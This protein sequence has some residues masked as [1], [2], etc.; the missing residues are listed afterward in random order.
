M[1]LGGTTSLGNLVICRGFALQLARKSAKMQAGYCWVVHGVLKIEI[2]MVRAPAQD[3]ILDHP[4]SCLD[5]G[6][7]HLL[8]LVVDVWGVRVRQ[9]VLP[10]LGLRLAPTALSELSLIDSDR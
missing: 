8:A 1:F 4:P 7:P 2:R 3:E 6:F 9:L 5:D 10:T